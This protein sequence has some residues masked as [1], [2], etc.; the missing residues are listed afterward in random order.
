MYSKKLLV[1]RARVFTFGKLLVLRARVFTFG[2]LLRDTFF[3]KVKK[4]F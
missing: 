3:E 2:K 1:L 4:G